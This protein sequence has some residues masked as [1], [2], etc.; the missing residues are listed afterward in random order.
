MRNITIYEA[1]R[2]G[3][4]ISRASIRPESTTVHEAAGAGLAIHKRFQMD[5]REIRVI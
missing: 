3:V 1:A 5:G 2:L 4:S